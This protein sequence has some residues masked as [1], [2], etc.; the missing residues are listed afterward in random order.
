MSYI[1]H[2]ILLLRIYL[3]QMVPIILII[4]FA[5]KLKL[6]DLLL[7][8]FPECMQ[9]LTATTLFQQNKPQRGPVD[10]IYLLE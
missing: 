3:I 1:V 9:C 7:V 6:T 5:Q 10:T 4:N 8:L 2:L